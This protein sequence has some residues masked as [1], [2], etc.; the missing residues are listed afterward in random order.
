MVLEKNNAVLNVNFKIWRH[1]QYARHIH[2]HSV[3]T[4]EKKTNVTIFYSSVAVLRLCFRNNISW[5]RHQM[6][7]FSA[8]LAIC[9]GNSPVSGEFPAQRPVTRSFYVF[10]DLR[11]N[12]R[13]SKQLCGWWFETHSSPLW[14]HNNVAVFFGDVVQNSHV[15]TMHECMDIRTV[16]REINYAEVPL[17]SNDFEFV[18]AGQITLG[19]MMDVI[20]FTFAAFWV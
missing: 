8:L 1:L 14:R 2:E 19:N 5:R 15:W 13:L 11:P 16:L 12:K 17:D 18:F 10:F 7:T 20:S 3:K 9:A 6:E 4:W